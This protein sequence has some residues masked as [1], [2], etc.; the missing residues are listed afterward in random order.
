MLMRL[1][2]CW[3]EYLITSYG[4][5]ANELQAVFIKMLDWQRLML[6]RRQIGH[7][8]IQGKKGTIFSFF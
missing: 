4:A 2:T 5:V 3:K 8:E 6:A 1:L 7:L